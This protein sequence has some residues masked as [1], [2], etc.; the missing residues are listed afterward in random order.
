MPSKDVQSRF[1]LDTSVAC[2]NH[3]MLG[4]CPAEVFERQNALRARIERQPS[5]FVLRELP[6]LLDEARQALAGVISADPADLALLPNVTTALSAVLRSRA[7]AP[8]DEI[9]TT[10]HAYLSC[11]NL[12]D[13]VARETGARVVTATVPTP[14]TGPDA[15][16]DAV[17]A[18]VT[19]RTRLAVLDHVTSPTGIVF[20][21]AAL[22]ERL[23][24][25][26]VDTVVDGAHAPG[27]LALDV[28]AIGAA[29]YAGNCHKWLC[30]PRGAGFLHVR[31]DRQDGLHPTVIS[32]GYGATSADRPRLHLEFDWL[33]TAD[34]TPLLCIPHAIRF[35]DGLLPGGLPAL[36]AHNHALVLD[37]ARRL[38]ADLPL[39]RLAPDSMVGSMVAFRLPGPPD[40]PGPASDDAAASLQRWLYDAHR[41]DVAVGAWPAA[42]RRVLRVSAQIYNT[43]DDFIRL[44]AA[45]R[46]APAHPRDANAATRTPAWSNAS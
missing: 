33:G 26:G 18:R 22:V 1:L 16:V 42:Q 38:A 5:A 12:L 9:L 21:I 31:R 40:S 39:V 19:P 24:A 13:F 10:D 34:P 6:G 37:G 46:G 15:I 4:A 3:G 11:S 41:I 43:I 30:S 32:R 44:G 7:F 25:R 36:M 45:L 28:R 29:Y 14:V 8:G 27:M 2:L 35:L 23:D 17:L 20:P